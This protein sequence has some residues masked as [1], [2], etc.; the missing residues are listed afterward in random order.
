[1]LQSF[2]RTKD[3]IQW[4]LD[5]IEQMPGKGRPHPM[6][7]MEPEIIRLDP[8]PLHRI[9][10]N[11]AQRVCRE[12]LIFA[13]FTSHWNSVKNSR[14]VRSYS[15]VVS[16]DPQFRKNEASTLSVSVSGP[17][18][19]KTSGSAGPF[20]SHWPYDQVC[21]E[22]RITGMSSWVLSQKSSS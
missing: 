12:R 6:G 18:T 16:A 8:G 13:A 7:W 2:D 20:M 3:I 15:R 4:R 19:G 1:L 5:R 21:H 11:V 10:Q 14:A 9:F 22:A 17:M